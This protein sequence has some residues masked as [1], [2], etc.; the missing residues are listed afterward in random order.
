MTGIVETP[1]FVFRLER[2]KSLRERAEER[3]REDLAHELRLR[4][5]G[6][7]MLLEATEAASA[8]TQ[9][10]RDAVTTRTSGMDLI[11]AQAYIERAER[12][13]R[14][15]ALDLDRQ[16]AEVAARRAAL[17][18]A[19]RDRQVLDKLK[20]RQRADHDA[21]WARKAQGALDEVAL[22]VH[23]RGIAA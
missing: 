19:A 13:K 3:A 6:E 4:L 1:S 21:E 8:A 10:G 12:T 9:S 16:D 18:A 22:S 23:R 17:Q 20:E 5:R 7:A 11:A 2:V 15:A 14:E